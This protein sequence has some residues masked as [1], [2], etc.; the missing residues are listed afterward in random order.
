MYID[1]VYLGLMPPAPAV[2]DSDLELEEEL[3]AC[4]PLKQLAAA[5]TAHI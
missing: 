3:L 4:Q 5:P 1:Y 2:D